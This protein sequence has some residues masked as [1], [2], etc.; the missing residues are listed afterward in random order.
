M[1]VFNVQINALTLVEE[2]DFEPVSTVALIV[3]NCQ[4]TTNVDAKYDVQLTK[5]PAIEP[6][7]CCMKF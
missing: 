3:Q 5:L 7:A 4:Y 1:V 6:N 2:A